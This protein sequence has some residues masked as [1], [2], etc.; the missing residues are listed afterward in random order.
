[1]R[2]WGG[3][4]EWQVFVFYASCFSWRFG[5]IVGE[6]PALPWGLSLQSGPVGVHG[7][8]KGPGVGGLD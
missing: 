4:G 6:E 1:M 8:D 5:T 3:Y 2:L 7:D